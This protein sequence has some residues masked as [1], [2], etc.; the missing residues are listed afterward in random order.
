[1]KRSDKFLTSSAIALC[2]LLLGSPSA[3]AAESA[4]PHK[5]RGTVTGIDMDQHLLVISDRK[6]NSVH[7]FQWNDQTRFTHHGKS[8]AARKL[9][10]GETVRLAYSPDGDVPVTQCVRIAPAKGGQTRREKA[11]TCEHPR[12][13]TPTHAPSRRR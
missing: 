9:Q 2:G 12:R 6:D 4:T 5:A 3:F 8:M 7:R 11:F 10:L 13:L 1:M